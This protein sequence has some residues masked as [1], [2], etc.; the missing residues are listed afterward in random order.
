M[1]LKRNTGSHIRLIGIF[2]K[3][4]SAFLGISRSGQNKHIIAA[5]FDYIKL[6]LENIFNLDLCVSSLMWHRGD[7]RECCFWNSIIKPSS[8]CVVWPQRCKILFI[9]VL[10]KD[11]ATNNSC[12]HSVTRTNTARRQTSRVDVY[13]TNI[14]IPTTKKRRLTFVLRGRPVCWKTENTQ[15]PGE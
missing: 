1:V 8:V 2:I 15:E 4:L 5:V 3:Q 12:C 7:P 6:E 9:N 10:L 11:K 14:K 13:P